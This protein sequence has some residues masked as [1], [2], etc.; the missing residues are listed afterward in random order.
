[1]HHEYDST[2]VFARIVRG[3]LPC[4]RVAENAHALA[5][6][7]IRPLMP[8]HVLLLPKG[9]YTDAVHF[10]AAA[11]P[12]EHAGL[13]ALLPEIVALKQLQSGFRLIANCGLNGGQEVPHLHWHIL[14][15]QKPFAMVPK[16]AL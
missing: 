13:W 16:A 11:S 15:G 4:N 5:F 10:A 1:M 9:A 2:N 12:E 8:V 6:D 3:D 14:A 7:D